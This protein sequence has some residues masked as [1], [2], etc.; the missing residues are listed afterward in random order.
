MNEVV[1]S[2][3]LKGDFTNVGNDGIRFTVVNR[4]KSDAVDE[5]F[6]L[7]YGSSADFL[8]QRATSGKRVVLT[9]RLS[10]EKLGT[11]NY[12]TAITASRILSVVDSSNG[13]DYTYA[14]V[15]GLAS[16]EG[17]V[18]MDNKNRTRLIGFNLVNKR[19]Y[20]TSDGETKEY[21]TYLG[22]TAWNKLAD[23]IAEDYD[24]PLQD[25][26]VVL[27]GILKP[28]SYENKNG[29]TIHKIDI[30]INTISLGAVSITTPPRSSQEKSPP[31]EQSKAPEKP[32]KSLEAA[33]ADTK[34]SSAD[35]LPF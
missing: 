35:N 27:D 23:K 15:G 18:E 8:K 21:S 12:H 7:A 26:P 4:G 29:D 25:V 20:T 2:G 19:E 5:F 13:T 9:G 22:A 34:K 30:W 6:C 1:L 24:C 32:T 17:L 31:K 28:R 16:T 11:E 33:L 10:S 14:V 3:I